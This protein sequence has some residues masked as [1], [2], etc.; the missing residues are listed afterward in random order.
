EDDEIAK[1]RAALDSCLLTDEE[2]KQ[3]QAGDVEDWEDPFEPCC[4]TI[5]VFIFQSSW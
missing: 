3:Y 1:I 2:M 4:S 5:S